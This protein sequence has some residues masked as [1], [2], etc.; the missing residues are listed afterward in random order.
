MVKSLIFVVLG[1]AI[2]VGGFYLTS[3]VGHTIA[4]MFT[5]AVVAVGI[6][7]AV[8]ALGVM[9]DINSPTSKKL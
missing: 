3:M 2:A 7:M 5:I 9:A 8:W 6:G 1:A 4:G